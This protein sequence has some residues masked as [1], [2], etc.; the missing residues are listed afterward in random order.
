MKKI[1]ILIT[2][3]MMVFLFGCEQTEGERCEANSDCEDDLICCPPNSSEGTC[4][5]EENCQTTKSM[6]KDEE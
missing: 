6:E 1:K 2:T 4:Q 5:Y 3:I